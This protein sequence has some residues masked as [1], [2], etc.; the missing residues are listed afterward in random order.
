[1]SRWD[2][3]VSR[4]VGAGITEGEGERLRW[5][6]ETCVR[7]WHRSDTY[8]VNLQ[9]GNGRCQGGEDHALRCTSTRSY[10]TK[11]VLARVAEF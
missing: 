4:F 9:R 7:L 8:K 6:R 3:K 2:W 5:L 10:S 11:Q 1:M